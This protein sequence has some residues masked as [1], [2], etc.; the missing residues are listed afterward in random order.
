MQ[1]KYP[2][3]KT[4]VYLV[5]SDQ[6][7]M[8]ELSQIFRSQ[9]FSALRM[10][11]HLIEKCPESLWL[12]STALTPFW[13]VAYHALYYTHIYLQPSENEYISWDKERGESHIL[14]Q[15]IPWDPSRKPHVGAPYSQAELL[16][17]LQFCFQQVEKQ[18][19]RMDWDAPSGF[20]WL[21][22]SKAELHLYNIRH[23]QQHVG[24]LSERLGRTGIEIPWE[25]MSSL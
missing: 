1:E 9:Y 4:R 14:S 7:V 20:S 24:E 16:E 5:Y 10:L 18:L 22:F 11:Q 13:Q 8:V 23:L 6:G 2:S 3:L 15:V 19:P 12:E 25:G 21:P 17:Y